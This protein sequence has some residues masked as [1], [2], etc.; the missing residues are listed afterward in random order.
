[1]LLLMPNSALHT[2]A[3]LLASI[4]ASQHF[5]EE[6]LT[7][8]SFPGK[9]IALLDKPL[10]F[11][12][13]DLTEDE[14]RAVAAALP[15]D[16][17][18]QRLAYGRYTI[19]FTGAD[20]PHATGPIHLNAKLDDVT[21]YQDPEYTHPFWSGQSSIKSYGEKTGAGALDVIPFKGID[22]AQQKTDTGK[23]LAN[24]ALPAA[25]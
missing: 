25:Q 21:L 18:G 7:L 15:V 10:L 23:P 8:T 12:G 19:T 13:V 17:N 22:P 3:L 11:D 1:M 14:A 5:C 16:G 24:S 2:R 9:F 4:G 20:A 6:G